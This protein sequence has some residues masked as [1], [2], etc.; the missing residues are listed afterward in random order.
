M[1]TDGGGW[2]R[3]RCFYRGPALSLVYQARQRRLEFAETFSRHSG[4]LRPSS[5]SCFW[6]YEA[7][8]RSDQQPLERIELIAITA[9]LI[10]EIGDRIHRG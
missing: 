9:Q 6:V 2:R 7:A 4:R 10:D 3:S 8:E 1:T 5:S